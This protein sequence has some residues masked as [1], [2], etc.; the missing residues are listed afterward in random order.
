MFHRIDTMKQLAEKKSVWYGKENMAKTRKEVDNKEYIKEIH[1]LY[2]IINSLKNTEE[3]KL[4]LKDILTRSELIMLKRRWHIANLLV[5]GMEM[6]DV[7]MEAHASTNTVIRV[8][9]ILEE[10]RGG[11]LLAIQKAK[12]QERED[13]K[14]YRKSKIP[15]QSSTFVKGW[16]R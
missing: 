7:A 6:R 9:K 15:K 4:F 13:I 2:E 5:L 3:V 10:G 16:F 12:D 11:L 14:K 1:F 8:K